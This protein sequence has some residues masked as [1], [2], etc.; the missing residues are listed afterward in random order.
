MIE[1]N[2]TNGIHQKQKHDL[3]WGH[4]S[5]GI[6][7]MAHFLSFPLVTNIENLIWFHKYIRP[8]R[9]YKFKKWSIHFIL[10][11]ARIAQRSL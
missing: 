6:L 9:K 3:E 1:Y 8:T 10:Y 11:L 4:K 7:G 2:I 5:D